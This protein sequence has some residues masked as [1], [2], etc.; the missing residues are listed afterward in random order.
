MR[1]ALVFKDGDKK[2]L[3][4]EGVFHGISIEYDEFQSGVV[5]MFPVAVIEDEKGN[6][7]WEHLW[8][9]RLVGEAK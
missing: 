7:T 4:Y 5:G 6:L 9:V 2:E 1:K 3:D 8:A